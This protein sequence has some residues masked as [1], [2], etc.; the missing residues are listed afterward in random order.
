[1]R[2]GISG[3]VGSIWRMMC[4]TNCEDGLLGDACTKSFSLENLYKEV[5]DEMEADRDRQNDKPILVEAK[6]ARSR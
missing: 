2:N 3:H 6:E 5:A 1:M 4:R